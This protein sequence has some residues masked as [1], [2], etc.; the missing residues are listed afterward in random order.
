M[1]DILNI[2]RK[3]TD[4]SIHC[5]ATK[6]NLDFYGPQATADIGVKEITQWHKERGFN[7]IGYH[8]VIRRNGIIEIGRDLNKAG[9]HVANHNSNSIGIC[10]VGG[11]DSKGKAEN[12]YTKEQWDSLLE[13]VK[14][15]RLKF[16]K[17]VI[18]GHRDYPNVAK[19]CPCFEVKEWCKLMHIE[20]D[21]RK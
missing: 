18:K 10:L 7:T 5:S 1:I 6:A 13:L 15:L 4:I 12:N 21:T 11:V 9:A 19:E 3:I 17:T 20:Q 16:P 2:T 14:A 8:F